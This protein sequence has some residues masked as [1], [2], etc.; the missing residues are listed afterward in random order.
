MDVTMWYFGHHLKE[1]D[2]LKKGE[3]TTCFCLMASLHL[4]SFSFHYAYA[5]YKAYC[6]HNLL[7]TSSSH[8]PRCRPPCLLEWRSARSFAR[9]A[10]EVCYPDGEEWG[11]VMGVMWGR[12]MVRLYMGRSGVMWESDG[13]A[14]HG[15]EWSDMGKSDGEAVHGEEWS[16]VGKS[17]GEAV[18]GEEWSDVG[19]SDGEAVHGEEWSDVGKSDGEAVHGE[20]WSDV[21]KSD[22]E[23]VGEGCM[24]II[25]R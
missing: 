14:V 2:Q 24:G 12:V 22:G 25:V 4:P 15:E 6:Q 17:D 5:G 20:E 16:D 8:L 1:N 21:G 7:R 10:L 11:G 13:E 9:T 18:H 3:F 23:V 19:K